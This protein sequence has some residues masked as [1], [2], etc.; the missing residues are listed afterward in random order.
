MSLTVAEL[1]A[2]LTSDPWR[3][4]NPFTV[5]M[6]EA[7]KNIFAAGDCGESISR[8][9]RDWLQKYQPCLFGRIAARQDLISYCVLTE[10][11]LCQNDEA[12]RTKIQDARLQWTRDA[13]DGKKSGFVILAVAPMLA[14]AAPDR[15]LKALARRLCSLYLLQQIDVDRIYHDEIFLEIQGEERSTWKWLAGVNYF[16]ANGDGRWWQD[17]RIPGG[18]AFSVNSVGH[19]AKTG[20]IAREAIDGKNQFLNASGKAAMPT[21]IDSLGKSLEFAMRTI[22]KA[23]DAVSGRATELLTLADHDPQSLRC[24][25]ELPSILM[26]K[27]FRYYRSYYH[28]D[29]T[30][31]S[32]YF[33]A[34]TRRPSH[35]KARMMDFL[36]LFDT[37]LENPDHI[38]TGT[39]R[40]IR[41]VSKKLMRLKPTYQ[42]ITAN[43]RLVRALDGRRLR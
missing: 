18:L 26:G 25:I 32:E 24:P 16:C 21:R 35:C 7:N 30:L 17:H 34:D 5:D 4:S 43:E 39:G 14:L 11:D 9:L 27:D 3:Q 2:K 12:I 22:S 40:R 1:L 15:N 19:L 23:S 29:F 20:A 42:L 37:D 41:S 10:R 28:T 33:T 31:P 36:Y 6:D 8:V 38:T 13:F